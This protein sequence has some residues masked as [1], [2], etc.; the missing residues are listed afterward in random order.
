MG[1]KLRE[2]KYYDHI[3]MITNYGMGMYES[4]VNGYMNL[5][6]YKL[7]T[8]TTD[9]G[10]IIIT[11]VVHGHVRIIKLLIDYVPESDINKCLVQSANHGHDN[12]VRTILTLRTIPE[13]IIEHAV[14]GASWYNYMSV[15]RLLIEKDSVISSD[16]FLGVCIKGNSYILKY[17]IRL[18]VNI[19]T[20][21]G[22]GLTYACRNKHADVVKMLLKNAIIIS[23]DNLRVIGQYMI[24]SDL[25][26]KIVDMLNDH[27]HFPKQ[28]DR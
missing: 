6:K 1:N 28:I 13:D 26:Q 3:N 22:K 14:S 15:L 16:S 18:G 12:V 5:I 25:N 7:N 19:N 24:Y 17:M 8:L 20:H 23:H 10:D 11:S 4:I 2:D 9:Y 21:D 27:F